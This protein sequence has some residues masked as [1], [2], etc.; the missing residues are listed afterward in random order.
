MSHFTRIKTQIVEQEYLIRALE[1]LGYAYEEGN[2]R[3]RGYG[4]QRTSVEIKVSTKSPGYDIGFRKVGNTYEIVADWWGV[5]GISQKKFVEQVT[6]RYAYH[7]ARAKLEEQGFTL[8]SEE[9]QEGERIHLVL[10]RMA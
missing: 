4:G 6:Q 3:I 7:A 8:A 5:R 2:V 9:M 1:D 10:R